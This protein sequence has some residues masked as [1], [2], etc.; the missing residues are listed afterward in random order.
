MTLTDLE[1]KKVVTTTKT[2]AE[3]AYEFKDLPK[4]KYAVTAAKSASFTTARKDVDLAAGE[5]KAGVE[6]KL[7]R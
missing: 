7:F 3:G 1:A 6:L 5:E 2:N 4:G